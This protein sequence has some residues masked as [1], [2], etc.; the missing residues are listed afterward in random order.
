MV[1]VANFIHFQQCKNSENWLRSVTEVQH[2]RDHLSSLLTDVSSCN[3]C[4]SR[5]LHSLGALSA[6][7]THL[8][9]TSDNVNTTDMRDNQP[10]SRSFSQP[11]VNS[12]KEANFAEIPQS[13]VSR[14]GCRCCYSS[15]KRTYRTVATD[16]YCLCLP[17]MFSR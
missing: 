3:N 16:C 11:L 4:Y 6:T 5:S 10:G 12:G 13:A 14:F 9:A 8:T 2:C 15:S 17:L 1:F 7:G